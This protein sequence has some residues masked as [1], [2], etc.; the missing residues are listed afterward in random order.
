MSAK[1]TKPDPDAPY[2]RKKDGTPKKKCGRPKL[3]PEK[4]KPTSGKRKAPLPPPTEA[5]LRK[6]R[7]H[8]QRGGFKKNNKPMPPT[9]DDA[10]FIRKG[11]GATV[12]K[13]GGGRPKGRYSMDRVIS[14][15]LK[16]MVGASKQT[17]GEALV[18]KL[19]DPEM[20][21]KH[22][23][24][25][26]VRFAAERIDGKP[27]Q[28]HVDLTNRDPLDGLSDEEI[29]KL[30]A[31]NGAEFEPDPVPAEENAPAPKPAPRQGE[32]ADGSSRSAKP[33]EAGEKS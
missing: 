29:D 3:P 32:A 23:L 1:R 21:S 19:F 7:L 24:L 17:I 20:I 31:V 12:Q 13:R 14:E 5:G 16:R 30:L 28:P 11:E 9:H 25:A 6:A 33:N 15:T 22:K 10:G 26:T 8:K 2:G 18:E 27:L 4:R